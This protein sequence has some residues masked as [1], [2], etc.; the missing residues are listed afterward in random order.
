MTQNK[1]PAGAEGRTFSNP[2]RRAEND[3]SNLREFAEGNVSP[4]TS[5]EQQIDIL[6]THHQHRW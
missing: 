2:E 6:D 1:P 5:S 3:L 4:L